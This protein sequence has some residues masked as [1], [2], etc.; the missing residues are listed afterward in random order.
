V[1]HTSLP[2]VIVDASN[3]AA[4]TVLAESRDATLHNI[5]TT[6]I[7]GREVDLRS[8]PTGG[9]DVV[10]P[11]TPFRILRKRM[12]ANEARAF[13][14]EA[15]S[16]VGRLAD[17]QVSYGV[18]EAIA[19]FRA[20]DH[21]EPGPRGPLFSTSTWGR[22][23]VGAMKRL[24]QLELTDRNL[25]SIAERLKVFNIQR[26]ATAPV[27][28]HPEKLGDLDEFY[29]S[30]VDVESESDAESTSISVAWISEPLPGDL[31]IDVTL[32]KDDLETAH[33]AFSS[34]G[35]HRVSASFDAIMYQVSL[36]RVPVLR[37]GGTFIRYAGVAVGL[38]SRQSLTF[39][40]G[41]RYNFALPVQ[42]RA[43]M[44][45]G[46]GQVPALRPRTELRFLVDRLRAGGNDSEFVYDP[47]EPN[48]IENAFRDLQ[49][50]GVHEDARDLYVIDPFV[51]N[52][53]ALRSIAAIASGREAQTR[54]WLLTK[55]EDVES[56][57]RD[58]GAGASRIP[59]PAEDASRKEQAEARF[60]ATAKRVQDALRLEIHVVPAKGISLH[61]R[62]LVV[63][64]RIWHVGHSFNAIGESLSAIVEMRDFAAK[65]RV[66][67]IVEEIIAKHQASGSGD[68]T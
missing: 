38:D 54:I 26:A 57:Q 16:G 44:R 21:V 67:A 66:F 19:S 14:T 33:V 4:L 36:D 41:G 50:L 47:R 28:R 48:V 7:Y 31:R 35:T 8:F 12:T 43:V 60:R 27:A 29:F 2:A 40:E 10:V 49:K 25:P 22:E 56:P 30:P 11:D 42:P 53:L 20:D 18:G 5:Y 34:A 45:A 3:A 52:E 68:G 9:D 1:Q 13:I 17:W 62:F 63:G 15:E 32:Y 59:P 55:F 58:A 24:E 51:L 39:G 61:D 6:V 64:G 37:S 23:R 65:A 46:T